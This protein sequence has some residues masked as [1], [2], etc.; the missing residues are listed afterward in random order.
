MWLTS[1]W[2]N[3]KVVV[4]IILAMLWGLSRDTNA[5]MLLATAGI[6]A[7][8]ALFRPRFWILTIVFTIIFLASNYTAQYGL[9]WVFPLKN[10]MGQRILVREE[11]TK[12]FRN[13]CQLPLTDNLFRLAG[14]W[15]GDFPKAPDPDG[16]YEWL[17]TNGKS[18]YMRYLLD[19]SNDT[20]KSVLPNM[21]SLLNGAVGYINTHLRDSLPPF[22]QKVIFPYWVYTYLILALIIIILPFVRLQRENLLSL[23]VPMI[24]LLL[25]Y[26]H[27][28][29]VYNGDAMEVERHALIVSITLR[30]GMWMLILI[31]ADG[32]LV[33]RF[34]T[35]LTK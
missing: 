25:V 18:C 29:L 17:L 9:R 8:L 1:G 4:I 22:V 13:Q 15:G 35:F 14:K 7:C 31:V 26:P 21:D 24:T 19:H 33:T 27:L 10:I 5:W 12:Y 11:N 23:L 28:L 20:L 6:I 16:I 32:I 2:K 3:R 30:L 34:K